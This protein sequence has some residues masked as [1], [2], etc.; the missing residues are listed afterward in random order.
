MVVKLLGKFM[1]NYLFQN[2]YETTREFS[3]LFGMVLDLFIVE[4]ESC[5]H[6]AGLLIT[7]RLL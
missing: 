4:V 1:L 6:Y 2:D 5:C 7:K 3:I